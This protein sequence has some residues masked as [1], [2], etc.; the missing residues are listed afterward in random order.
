M[1][2]ESILTEYPGFRDYLEEVV[3]IGSLARPASLEEDGFRQHAGALTKDVFA[4]Y[5]H[6][7]NVWEAWDSFVRAAEQL[8]IEKREYGEQC[9]AVRAA[10]VERC[11]TAVFSA[12]LLRESVSMLKAGKAVEDVI[13]YTVEHEARAAAL[14]EAKISFQ[15]S[16]EAELVASIG[17]QHRPERT[18]E[19]QPGRDRPD[20]GPRRR[21]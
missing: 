21:S 2:S 4:S 3:E 16:D 14:H 6:G 20:S 9:K 10:F 12:D 11:P 7:D 5:L 17:E 1:P 8:G 13:E 18:Q 19:Q 15:R